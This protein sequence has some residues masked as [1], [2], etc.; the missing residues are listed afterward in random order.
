[1]TP[2]GSRHMANKV[3]LIRGSR[4]QDEL[5]IQLGLTAPGPKGEKQTKWLYRES[6][7]PGET[8]LPA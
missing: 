3:L 5:T 4:E 1:M 2:L 8:V 6:L 7:G